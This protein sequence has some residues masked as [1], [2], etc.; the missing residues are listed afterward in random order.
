VALLGSAPDA[1]WAFA[2]GSVVSLLWS[3]RSASRTGW[4]AAGALVAVG[5]EVAQ[6]VA[7]VPGTF[8]VIDLVASAMAYA[9]AVV[10]NRKQET[11]TST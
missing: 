8:D 4:I 5:Y 7:L 6:L 9:L 11:W 10:V 1:A 2:T 3:S